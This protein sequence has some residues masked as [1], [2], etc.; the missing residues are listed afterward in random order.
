[1]LL[2]GL[3]LGYWPLVAILAF[4]VL[5]AWRHF[6]G[7]KKA[8][9]ILSIA[10]T[11]TV[12]A[13]IG[14]FR[15]IANQSKVTLIDFDILSLAFGGLFLWMIKFAAVTRKMNRK[16]AVA[17][18]L[19]W[20]LLF[21]GIGAQYLIG[22]FALPRN[23]VS[24]TVTNIY[25]ETSRSGRSYHVFI[26]GHHHPTTADVFYEIDKDKRIRAEVG[27][28]SGYIFHVERL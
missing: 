21:G 3:A 10:A 11:I 8:Q 1:M 9:N 24:G 17:T 27:A 26:D 23:V 2:T 19:F 13:L 12:F 4:V 20:A 6:G 15:L 25:E 7:N 18:M 5:R 14:V 16:F 22:D 28:G